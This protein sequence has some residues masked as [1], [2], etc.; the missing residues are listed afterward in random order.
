MYSKSS[1]MTRLLSLETASSTDPHSVP[2]LGAEPLGQLVKISHDDLV[3][4]VW[5]RIRGPGRAPFGRAFHEGAS[6]ARLA[7]CHQIEVVTRD[8]QELGRPVSEPLRA[9]VISRRASLVDTY[10]LAR[11]DVIP[12]EPVA[13]R[14]VDDQRRAQDREGDDNVLLSQTSERRREI[15]PGVERMP[16]ASD[17]F[18]ILL[19]ELR[20]VM[21]LNHRVE[22]VAMYII[23]VERRG[24]LPHHGLERAPAILVG[25]RRPVGVYPPS[26]SRVREGLAQASMPVEDGASDV[27]CQ[28]LDLRH[29][30]GGWGLPSP[31]RL[32][33]LESG[34]LQ[35]GHHF[36]LRWKRR[37]L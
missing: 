13:P 10:H 35:N 19:R 28:R 12:G 20:Q 15:R 27:E 25:D 17:C 8:H 2:V 5:Y 36:A 7:R 18:A 22:H 29:H 11:Y 6:V 21:S 34:H 23:D 31:S 30:A 3:G 1:A 37:W 16:C 4:R 24:G 26:G 9:G 14:H 33:A 32:G